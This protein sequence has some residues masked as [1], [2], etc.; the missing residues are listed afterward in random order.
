[1]PNLSRYTE[2]SLDLITKARDA[3]YDNRNSQV[4]PLHLLIQIVQDKEGI[5][6]KLL[7]MCAIDPS[8]VHRKAK[9]VLE[10]IP[11]LSEPADEIFF[12]IE[13]TRLLDSAEEEAKRFK[14]DFV[15]VE[16]IILAMV[17]SDQSP[18]G[19]ILRELDATETSILRALKKLRGHTRIT[20]QTPESKFQAMGN[21]GI[22]Y[23]ELAR[24]GK[25]DPVIGRQDEIRRVMKVL[26]RRRKNNP[27]LI[28][29]PGV[30]KTAIVEGLAQK[31][32][33]GDV[34]ESLRDA[35]LVQLDLGR[36]IAGAKF[37]GEFEDRL[38]AFV[39]EVVE[40]EGK[41]IL[42]IDEMH[43][44]VGA[45]A[46]EG[47]IDASNMLKP[48]LARGELRAIGA[49]TFDE[50]RKYIEKDPAL[51]R[52]FAPII[53]E[54]N[55]VAETISILRG[56]K[57]K[58]EVHHGVTITD[59]AIVS[60]AKLADRYIS[61]RFLPDKAIDLIDEAAANLRIDLFSQPADLDEVEKQIQQLEIEK[62]GLEKGANK[63]KVEAI[64]KEIA[65]LSD[66]RDKLS[67]QWHIEKEIIGKIREIQERLDRAKTELETAE[68]AGDLEAAAR[69]KYGGISALQKMLDEQRIKLAE[70]QSGIKLLREEVTE[71][72]IAAVLSSWTGIPVAKL[73]EAETEKLLRLEDELKHR[74]VG[75][76]GAIEAVADV[77]RSARAGIADPKKP[78][79]SFIFLGS[80]GVGKTE[81]AK[82]LALA[83]FD[84]E[85]ALI[86]IDMSEYMEKFSVSRLIG[87][88]PGY[89]GYDEGGQLTEAVRRHP[90]SVVLFDEIEK[91]H[92][93]VFN[94]LLQVLDDGRLT[95]N[96]GRTVSF[97]NTILIM[98]SNIGSRMLIESEGGDVEER[99]MALLK[100]ALPPEFLNRIDDI[101][102]FNPL[103]PDD[104]AQIVRIQFEELNARLAERDISLELSDTAAMF[105][106]KEGF[107]PAFGAR[108]VK[109]VLTHT[110]AKRVSS[111]ILRGEI[112]PGDRARI[113][114]KDGEI[115]I[116]KLKGKE[117]KD[118]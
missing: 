64:A 52:R 96:K 3:A 15:S 70:A 63:T 21:Y 113:D 6:A 59:D 62:R 61:G 47:A 12:S 11:I 2:A 112:L 83:L 46:A 4:E 98:T 53:V 71:E 51:E 5:G 74:V 85:D 89:V 82:T 67:M 34:P 1:M 43:T 39:K 16:H 24:R 48:P 107:D 114:V 32:I 76:D 93:E 20:D 58:Y 36:L 49:T 87:A 72:D 7:G 33:A 100:E 18:A 60:A 106:A 31:I 97:N 56:L 30:G 50:Y 69:I 14:D 99:L 26:S 23:T 86:R 9:D 38:K 110:V 55:T 80:T 118:S 105:L 81:L 115:V 104:V 25:L 116:E 109:R 41:V 88:P 108:P 42:F 102:I 35:R 68:R 54:E 29:E 111:A 65:E 10:G 78:L 66:K 22:D 95:D 94:L 27:A 40:S 91:A 13:M 90:Y 92:P 77:V 101:V 19:G 84:D 17:K 57:E 103:S 28:G 45:G 8:E 73:T 37:R 117:T 79:G 75:Q 44:I